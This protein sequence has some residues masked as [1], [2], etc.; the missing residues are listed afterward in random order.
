M[1][2]TDEYSHFCE[3]GDGFPSTKTLKGHVEASDNEECGINTGVKDVPEEERARNMSP[4]NN[5]D[6]MSIED[7]ISTLMPGKA[8]LDNLSVRRTG[9]NKYRVL[10][11]RNGG[12]SYHEVSLGQ[13]VSCT[14]EDFEYNTGGEPCAH[15][16]ATHLD[17]EDCDAGDIAMADV[18]QLMVESRRLAEMAQDAS[19]GAQSA[20]GG[21][22]GGETTTNENASEGQS[23]GSVSAEDAANRL[24]S[25]YDDVV[26]DMGVQAYN[27]MVWVQTGKDT[28]E[29]LP[30]PGNVE[31]F[32]AFLQGPD[33]VQYRPPDDNDTP[34]EWWKNAIEPEDVDEYISEVLE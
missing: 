11:A 10:S 19:V 17:A 13:E 25:A 3:C 18:T 22:G 15:I 31:V 8:P 30:G 12:V 9:L 27:G 24:Q 4:D 1:T 20:S 23:G 16:V 14:C 34:G 33:Q 28:P 6:G 26:D 2:D 21:S 32:S 5:E 29:T 7:E